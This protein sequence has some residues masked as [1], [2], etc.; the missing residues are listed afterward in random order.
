MQ[1]GSKNE[2]IRVEKDDAVT[3]DIDD[4]SD[5]ASKSDEDED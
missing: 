5:S 4:D 1:H 2:V 3:D